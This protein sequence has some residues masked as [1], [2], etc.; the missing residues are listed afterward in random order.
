M[1]RDLLCNACR[2]LHRRCD[3]PE[4]SG[5]LHY[6]DWLYVDE[7]G[8]RQINDIMGDYTTERHGKKK[9]RILIRQHVDIFV[10]TWDEEHYVGVRQ[11]DVYHLEMI[12]GEKQ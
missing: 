1:S 10:D 6:G 5:K 7:F 4:V 8:Y 12:R 11:L 3:H 2:Q 9:V